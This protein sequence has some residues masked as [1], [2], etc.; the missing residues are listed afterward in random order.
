MIVVVTQMTTQGGM[1]AL[2]GACSVGGTNPQQIDAPS[3]NLSMYAGTFP[4]RPHDDGLGE[5]NI[6]H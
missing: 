6:I 5:H 3:D 1:P 4:T 2:P